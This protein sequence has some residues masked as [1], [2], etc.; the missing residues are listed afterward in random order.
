MSGNRIETKAEFAAANTRRHHLISREYGQGRLSAD[1]QGELERLQAMT[2]EWVERR[3]P[4]AAR[5]REAIA[6]ID[7][8]IESTNHQED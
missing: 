6:V 8:L 4:C 5:V 3:S 1:E 7:S 2:E